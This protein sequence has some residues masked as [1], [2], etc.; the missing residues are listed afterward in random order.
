MRSDHRPMT[1][2]TRILIPVRKCGCR[3]CGTI[4]RVRVRG[5]SPDSTFPGVA[6]RREP[7]VD[8]ADVEQV[9]FQMGGQFEGYRSE[10]TAEQPGIEY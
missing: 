3:N 2:S 6:A 10:A 4:S 8:N 5:R 9:T 7:T 1:Q